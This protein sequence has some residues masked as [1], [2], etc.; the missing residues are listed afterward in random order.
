MYIHGDQRINR[1]RELLKKNAPAVF[2]SVQSSSTQEQQTL[3]NSLSVGEQKPTTEET[4]VGNTALITDRP[5][6]IS[7]TL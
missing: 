5:T 3:N 2:N 7:E 6:E 4:L 1:F